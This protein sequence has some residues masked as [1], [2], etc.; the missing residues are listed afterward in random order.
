MKIA[1][2]DMNEISFERVHWLPS[3]SN[4]QDSGKIRPVIANFSFYQDKKLIWSKG[5]N[6][7]GTRIGI[8]HDF[9]KEIDKIHVKPYPVR[10]SF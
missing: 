9:P 2:E 8:S 7:K 4:R 5:K 3:R 1:R 6:L 10:T